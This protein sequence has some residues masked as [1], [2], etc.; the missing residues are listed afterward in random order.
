MISSGRSVL[1]VS[2]LLLATSV[3]ACSGS[4]AEPMANADPAAAGDQDTSED[5]L[6]TKARFT[7]LKK[8]TDKDLNDFF[9]ATGKL[10][11]AY[12]GIYR[13]NKAGPEATDPD[14][15][16]KRVKEVMH[17]YMCGFFDESIDLGRS[18]GANAV[19][20]TLGDVD[21]DSNASDA[22]NA[23][24]AKLASTLGEVFKNKKLDVMSGSASGNN[25]MGEVMG[26]YDMKNNEVLYFGFTNC[27][28]D[29]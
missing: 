3:T 28:S 20:A 25:T 17:R 11:S 13:F 19:K 1:V 4:A 27:G 15:R 9:A 16:M 22:S 8:A 6:N 5:E 24:T 7:H 10:E 26:I 2:L 14:A 23:D 12:R 29:D 21:L 18:T